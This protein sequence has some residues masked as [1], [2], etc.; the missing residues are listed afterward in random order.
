MLWGLVHRDRDDGPPPWCPRLHSVLARG[1]GPGRRV[2]EPGDRRGGRGGPL[3]LLLRVAG[4]AVFTGAAGVLFCELRV[5]SR[6]LLA[7]C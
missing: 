4:T 6:S 3:G 7:P 2:G 1:A 5:R